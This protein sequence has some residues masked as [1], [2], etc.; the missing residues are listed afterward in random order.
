LEVVAYEG[1]VLDFC[2]TAAQRNMVRALVLATTAGD[3][4]DGLLAYVARPPTDCV[5]AAQPAGDFTTILDL[6]ELF[7]RSRVSGYADKMP[8][9]RL[10][11]PLLRAI[12]Y[13]R[14]VDE[15]EP[16]LRDLRPRYVQG[17][18]RLLAVRGRV[19]DASLAEVQM[20]GPPS[21]VCTFD[22]LTSNTDLAIIILAALGVVARFGGSPR[23]AHFHQPARKRAARL[24]RA[25]NTVPVVSRIDAAFRASRLRLSRF[26]QRFESA[27]ELA[28]QVLSDST[29]G[30]T[31]V[32]A[33]TDGT[34]FTFTVPTAK[35][36][37]HVLGVALSRL[38][39]AGSVAIQPSLPSPW[40]EAE[41]ARQPDFVARIPHGDQT[42][43]L[44]AKYKQFPAALPGADDANQLFV[45][46]HLARFEGRAPT[47]A[48]LLYASVG[49]E[50]C[51]VLER[52]PDKAVELRLAGL[53]FPTP[54]DLRGDR[55]WGSYLERLQLALHELFESA[56]AHP[57]MRVVG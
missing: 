12:L 29:V 54:S 11:H 26:E 53:P 9:A 39:P 22:E 24:A 46:S 15:V 10:P 57:V 20:G 38:L 35:L 37:E 51:R 43:V 3:S 41:N 56:E 14:L 47:H 1:D 34:P 16:L 28:R 50:A 55:R 40:G 5:L 2:G 27:L 25:L 33:I 49:G 13:R 30:P 32:D 44:D 7:E 18:E 17:E 52:Q 6:V 4:S 45:Y 36:W 8:L 42:W 21:V 19:A 31:D 48:A 23:L